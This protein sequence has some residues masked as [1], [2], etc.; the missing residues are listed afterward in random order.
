MRAFLLGTAI[1]LALL[2]AAAVASARPAHAAAPAPV[3][4]VAPSAAS[5]LQAAVSPGTDASAQESGWVQYGAF[6]VALVVLLVIGT[7]LVPRRR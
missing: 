2:A 7:G 6:G 5:K 3:T 1:A 4:A